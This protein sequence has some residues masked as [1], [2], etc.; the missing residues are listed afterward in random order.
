[1]QD[2]VERLQRI[3]GRPI[4]VLQD[5]ARIRTS[6]RPMLVAD[7]GRIHRA[8]AWRP[9]SSLDDTLTDMVTAYGLQTEPHLDP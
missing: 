7:I 3:L 9:R 8:T 4:T 2:I 5:P 1:M 6:E